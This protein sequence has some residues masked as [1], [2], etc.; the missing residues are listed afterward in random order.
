MQYSTDEDKM[1][2]DVLKRTPGKNTAVQQ[3]PANDCK[4]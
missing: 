3:I 2:T 4:K 1:Q